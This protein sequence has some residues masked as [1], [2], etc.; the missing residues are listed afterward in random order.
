MRTL[1]RRC[2]TLF[3]TVPGVL[4]CETSCTRER[5]AR[6]L[7]IRRMTAVH[8]RPCPNISALPSS[9]S[10]RVVSQLRAGR[11]TILRAQHRRH[12][13]MLGVPHRRRRAE[14]IPGGDEHDISRPQ[15]VPG[16]RAQAPGR[17]A[18]SCPGLNLHSSQFESASVSRIRTY[19]YVRVCV[20]F[21]FGSS[22]RSLPPRASF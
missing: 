21:Y 5:S 2:T 13:A 3:R 22:V 12:Q 16:G 1:L 10:P 11:R 4:R 20:F 9:L 6:S 14:R 7:G 17:G 15:L 18:R 8:G 19:V